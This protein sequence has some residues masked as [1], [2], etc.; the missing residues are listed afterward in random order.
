M[1]EISVENSQGKRYTFNN[2]NEFVVYK[3]EGLNPPQATLNKSSN[4]TT[5]G[6]KVT[7]AKVE[8]RNLVIYTTIEN[9]AEENRNKLYEYFQ[10]AGKATIFYKSGLKDVYI[11]GIVETLEVGAFEEKETA[12]ISIVCEKP[13]FKSVDYIVTSFSSVVSLFEF[14]FS[15]PES[16]IEFSTI[17]TN[18]RKKIVNTGDVKT[19]AI[20]R[21][22]ATGTVKNPILYDV[23]KKTHMKLKITM[24]PSDEIVINTNQREKSITLVRNGEIT[25]ILG[26]MQ[27][28]S[29][30]FTLE[31]GDN[32]F[33]YTCESG[34][35][36]LM[37]TFTTIPQ[38]GGV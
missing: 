35:T 26:A 27:K 1:F 11:E 8:S 29:E 22:Y 25:N 2:P 37:I 36:N 31:P 7:S 15:I 20:I 30:F 19:G 17:T 12:Q 3:I 38:Y 24:K 32:I 28:D 18:I 13:F 34:D 14:P 6:C 23:L 4:A 9:D 5:D 16:G 10:V 21:M 33:A